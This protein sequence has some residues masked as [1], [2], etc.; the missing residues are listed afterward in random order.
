MYPHAVDL[1]LSVWATVSALPGKIPETISSFEAVVLIQHGSH[2][3]VQTFV[4]VVG[5]AIIFSKPSI[6]GP[7]H[8]ADQN[9]QRSTI[10]TAAK[11]FGAVQ[12]AQ[13]NIAAGAAMIAAAIQ[14]IYSRLA[15]RTS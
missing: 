12:A 2:Q 9:Q 3:L 13:A 11:D 10:S 1:V 6:H 15:L 8:L 14:P 7:Q 4:S 5:A